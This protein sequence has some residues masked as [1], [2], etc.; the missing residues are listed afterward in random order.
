MTI[1]NWVSWWYREWMWYWHGSIR[2]KD[3][4]PLRILIGLSYA[5]IKLYSYHL[6]SLETQKH[7]LEN[8]VTKA[9]SSNTSSFIHGIDIWQLKLNKHTERW[10][11]KLEK[12]PRASIRFHEQEKRR[13]DGI[14]M[15]RKWNGC[16]VQ[17]LC[18]I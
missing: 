7:Q 18:F 3:S 10:E 13:K 16:H 2:I 15:S 9:Y 5:N 1:I 6:I 17:N 11:K 12:K 8:E 4:A 14:V